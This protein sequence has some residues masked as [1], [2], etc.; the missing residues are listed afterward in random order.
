MFD[1][2]FDPLVRDLE[3][4]R[5]RVRAAIAGTIV[6]TSFRVKLPRRLAEV[7]VPAGRCRPVRRAARSIPMSALVPDLPVRA[8]GK[9]LKLPVVAGEAAR[10]AEQAASA[11]HGQLEFLAVLLLWAEVA[12]RDANVER[13]RRAA[14]GSRQGA[15]GGG[16]SIRCCR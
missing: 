7:A 6:S 9:R 16:A 1:H 2:I 5:R 10:F 4:N 15:P 11:G 13:S 3:L 14:A 12:G 8:H